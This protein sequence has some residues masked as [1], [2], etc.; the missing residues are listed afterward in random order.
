VLEIVLI[1]KFEMAIV[2]NGT[3]IECRMTPLNVVVVVVDV[4]D[5]SCMSIGVR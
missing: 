2:C 5:C 4:D 1:V 3:K